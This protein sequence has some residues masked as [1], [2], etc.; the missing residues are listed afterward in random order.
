MRHRKLKETTKLRGKAKPTE[1]EE[2]L[3]IIK[4]I[5]KVI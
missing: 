1:S 2:G 3:E 4:R 5:F